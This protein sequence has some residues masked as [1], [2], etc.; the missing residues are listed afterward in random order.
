MNEIERCTAAN[1]VERCIFADVEVGLESAGQGGDVLFGNPNRHVHVSRGARLS[2]ER[3]GE[4]ATQHIWNPETI[5]NGYYAQRDIE[6]ALCQSSAL[7]FRIPAERV[8]HELS[9]DGEC[10]EPQCLL[11]A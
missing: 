7:A 3:A 2:D 4:G 8:D 10:A 11:S 9:L 5:E 6:R 1:C